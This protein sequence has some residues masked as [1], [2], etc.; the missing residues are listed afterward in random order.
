MTQTGNSELRKRLIAWLLLFAWVGFIYLT[1][2]TVPDWRDTLVERYGESVFTTITFAGGALGLA[3]LLGVM[4]FYYRQKRALPYIALFLNLAFFVWALKVWIALPVEQIHFVE[5]GIVGFLSF[6]A[7]R[8]HLKGWGLISAAVLLTFLFG[9]VDETIQGLL[10]NRVGEQRDMLWNG[11]AGAIVM[12]V[13][14]FSLRPRVLAEKSGVREIKAHLLM[15]ALYLLVQGYFNTRI[16]QFGYLIQDQEY[17]LTFKSRLQPEEL[18][19][20]DVNLDHWKKNIAPKIGKVRMNE[21]LP[22]VY[23]PIHEEALVH[24]FR[25]AYHFRLGNIRTVYSE[26]LI[27]NRYYKNFVSG[28]KQDW[29]RSLS[30]Q[31]RP[32]VGERFEIPYHSIVA[33]HLITRFTAMQMW[34]VIGILEAVIAVLWLMLKKRSGR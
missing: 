6:N 5:Y 31:M 22:Q 32:V 11:L 15:A 20:Y 18:I 25:R 2:G 17:N 1:L 4:I 26:D 28:T 13:E 16:A 14:A 19:A 24:C 27:I 23:N 9:A 12:S 3:V 21:L 8:H 34:L 7:L 33:N 10:E 30:E 29:P